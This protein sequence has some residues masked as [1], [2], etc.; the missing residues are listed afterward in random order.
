MSILTL[1]ICFLFINVFIE[2]YRIEN[3]II[4]ENNFYEDKES[5]AIDYVYA[6]TSNTIIN[7]VF[8]LGSFFIFLSII[9]LIS[10][11]IFLVLICDLILFFILSILY[12]LLI[13]YVVNINDKIINKLGIYYL[14]LLLVLLIT[15]SILLLLNILSIISFL[16]V[17]YIGMALLSYLMYFF[18]FLRR[19]TPL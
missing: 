16:F 4:N 10:N 11:N 3:T 13:K 18:F 17:N 14:I 12:G 6:N 19:E 9:Y 7:I 15:F 8:L 5:K 2:K 1:G